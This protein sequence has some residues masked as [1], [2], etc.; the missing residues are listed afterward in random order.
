[1]NQNELELPENLDS[2]AEPRH[3]RVDGVSFRPQP[4]GYGL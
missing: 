1:M 4:K 2:S 3:R